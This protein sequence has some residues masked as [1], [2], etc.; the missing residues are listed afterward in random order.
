MDRLIGRRSSLYTRTVLI[1]SATL[2]I[3][4]EFEPVRD[5]GTTDPRRYGG[6]PALKLPVL[7]GRNGELFG[8]LNICRALADR[9]DEEASPERGPRI[10]WPEELRHDLC[11]NAQELV[12]DGMTAQVQLV[13]STLVGNVAPHEHFVIKT[14]SGLE[15]SLHWLDAN[16]GEVLQVIPEPRVLSWFE[17]SLF[18]LVEHLTFRLTVPMH[19][20]TALVRFARAYAERPAIRGTSY[21]FDP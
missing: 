8:A 9:A 1:F 5:L 18:C 12:A 6:N 4:C 10:I 20:Y 3:P 19:D 16:L 2:G 14:R 7:H 15:G 21:Q 11:R 17:V 13:M